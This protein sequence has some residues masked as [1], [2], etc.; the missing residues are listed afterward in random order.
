M[1]WR[2]LYGGD[3]SGGVPGGG[4]DL[5]LV[6]PFM[7]AFLMVRHV[8][9]A[10]LSVLPILRLQEGGGRGRPVVVVVVVVSIAVARS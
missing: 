1:T 4:G 8:R 2:R 10:H 6:P 5:A 7:M 9:R 3:P